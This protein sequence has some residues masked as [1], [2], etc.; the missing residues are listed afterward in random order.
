MKAPNLTLSQRL[1][2]LTAFALLPALAI[3]GFNEWSLRRSREA[4]VHSY[5]A[6]VSE[7]AALELNRV[8]TGAAALM[9][10]VG[11]APVVQ[12]GNGQ[13]CAD[14]LARL[15][16]ALPQLALL[17][18]TDMQGTVL[19]SSDGQ[20]D[21]VDQEGAQLRAD[22]ATRDFAIG[23]YRE[24]G[25]G[26]GLPMGARIASPPGNDP[27]YVTAVISLHYLGELIAGRSF[28]QGSALTVA[29][30][31]G[32]ILARE[33]FPE[34]FVGTRI[35][36]SFMPL[37]QGDAPGTLEVTSQDGTRRVIGYQ[38]ATSR[39]GLYV[40]AGSAVD[41]AFAP[42]NES[43]LR[44][45]G[46]ALSG[47]LLAAVLAWGFGR[48]F[49]RRPLQR[50]VDTIRI[51]RSGD[52]TARTGMG[53]GSAEFDQVGHAID[54]MLDEIDERQ[55]AQNRAEQHRDL[56]AREL[57]H[58]V[59][60][61][62]ATVQALARQTFREGDVSG[63]A[64]R[65]FNERLRAMGD[66][67]R[68]LTEGEVEGADMQAA[69]AAAIGPF[70]GDGR[71]RFE[72]AGPSLFLRPKATLSL[73]MALHEL[74]TNAVK[75]GA[76]AS[77]EGR[78]SIAWAVAE[79]DHLTIA[80]RESGGPPVAPPTGKGFG[81]RMIERALAADLGA[82]VSFDYAATGL[83]CTITADRHVMVGDGSAPGGEASADAA[84]AS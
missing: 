10:A 4:E 5:A 79:P 54:A 26:P 76:L 41:D 70:E 18:I 77:E 68:L 78:V 57:D 16:A 8:L 65:V 27:I 53:P 50:L 28:Q 3:L 83:V 32:I 33:P 14:Y 73:S 19:C 21:V 69:I 46:L 66:A 75:Y 2:L 22:L 29:D 13:G 71:K 12:D 49:I 25:Q 40:S 48:S 36:E 61:L 7:L 43:T 81:S 74:C 82:R 6:Q 55:A 15:Q 44:G 42:I 23:T 67:H 11:N 24:T 38:P 60:N 62:L 80:W 17:R 35:P 51:W 72:L 1:F 52:H 64:L 63:T 39:L 34:R 56:L 9:V 45:V 58:R 47:G 84:L 20:A 37:V 59:K 30:R 31:N